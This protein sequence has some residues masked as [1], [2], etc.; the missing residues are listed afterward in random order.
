MLIV[1][2][3]VIIAVVIF[4]GIIVSSTSILMR[5]QY[6]W[7]V[8]IFPSSSLRLAEIYLLYLDTRAEVGKNAV[9]DLRS[10]I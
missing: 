7:F 10:S 6:F 4:T 1:L 5:T 2:H 3:G 8:A 9:C